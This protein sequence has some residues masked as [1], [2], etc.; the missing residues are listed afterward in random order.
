MNVASWGRY[1][2]CYFSGRA[3][4]GGALAAD[5]KICRHTASAK[6]LNFLSFAIADGLRHP[7]VDGV[8][9]KIEQTD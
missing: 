6:R 4:A 3:C 8:R 2:S 9:V 7:I 5:V 1:T